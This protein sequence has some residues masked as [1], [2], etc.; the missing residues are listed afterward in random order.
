MTEVVKNKYET[1]IVLSAKLGEEGNAELVE[2]FKALIAKHGTVES[3]DE[4]GK[5]RLAY[6]INKETEGYY[7]LVN[8]ESTP[9]FTAELDRRYKI[10]DGVLRSIIVK[11]DPRFVTAAAK[12]RKAAEPKPIDVEAVAVEVVEAN[13][14]AAE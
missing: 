14:S 13:E 11:K 10:T 6:P 1:V 8:F 12:P 7:T 3:V 9:D 4:W 2:K 5:R